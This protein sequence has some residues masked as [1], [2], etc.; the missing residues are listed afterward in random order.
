MLLILIVLF[1]SNENKQT[2]KQTNTQRN[3]EAFAD[4]GKRGQE[5]NQQRREH[6]VSPLSCDFGFALTNVIFYIPDFL[7]CCLVLCHL[8][9]IQLFWKRAPHLGNCRHPYHISLGV[10]LWRI[11]FM[12]G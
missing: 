7:P 4:L 10:S 11:F 3:K 1:H 2:N 5:N 12:D 9:T 6:T 8:D